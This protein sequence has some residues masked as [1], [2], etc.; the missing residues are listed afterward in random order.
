LTD[1]LPEEGLPRINMAA[2]CCNDVRWNGA[3]RWALIEREY[4]KTSF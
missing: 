2:V 1:S 4:Y 3:L